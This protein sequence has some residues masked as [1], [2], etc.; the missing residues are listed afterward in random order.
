VPAA[1]LRSTRACRDDRT[2]GKMLNPSWANPGAASV[3][4]R[5]AVGNAH[6]PL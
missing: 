2:A 6:T 4:Y 3:H 5:A 1:R